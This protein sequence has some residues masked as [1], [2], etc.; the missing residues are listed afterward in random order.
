M[1][2]FE[3]LKQVFE[4]LDEIYALVSGNEYE[5]YLNYHLSV[6]KFEVQRQLTNLKNRSKMEK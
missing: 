2:E 4:K 5:K 6:V 1:N 3:R